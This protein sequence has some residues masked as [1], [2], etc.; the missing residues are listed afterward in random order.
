[1]TIT[2]TGDVAFKQKLFRVL[3][4]N[5]LSGRSAYSLGFATKNSNSGWSFG[6][7]QY[8]LSTSQ[9]GR[10][11]FRNILEN[12]K[13]ANGNFII[14]D[15]DPATTRANDRT[16]ADL[17]TKARQKSATALT[18][19]EQALINAALSSTDGLAIIDAAVDGCDAPPYLRE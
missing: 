13:D 5:E 1:M 11:L 17:E 19:A 4:Q 8:D 7:V 12:A 10:T 6:W 16:I 14:D 9:D 2:F 15:G 3:E 18:P